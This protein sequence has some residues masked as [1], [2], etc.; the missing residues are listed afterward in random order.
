MAGARLPEAAVHD[1]GVRH[2]RQP[3]AKRAEGVAAGRQ[4][5]TSS[6]ELWGGGSKARHVGAVAVPMQPGGRGRSAM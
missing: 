3:L 6:R 5:R 2:D 1:V 4:S